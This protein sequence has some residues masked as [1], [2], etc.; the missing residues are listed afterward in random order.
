MHNT[1]KSNKKL[2][3]YQK[4]EI[5]TEE[6]CKKAG[7]QLSALKR[8]SFYRSSNDKYQSVYPQPLSILSAV[9][10]PCSAPNA[11]C[12]DNIQERALKCI[13]FNH[14]ASDES[15]LNKA[16]LPPPDVGRQINIAIQTLKILNDLAPTSA[17]TYILELMENTHNLRISENSS[18]E[19][20][21]NTFIYGYGTHSFW[22]QRH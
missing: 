10:Y 1:F 16:R 22:S 2:G 19:E 11:R 6:I 17:P 15:L 7:R 20:I 14:T 3:L 8:L 9:R 12:M 18:H 5:H 4:R 13:Y 21:W